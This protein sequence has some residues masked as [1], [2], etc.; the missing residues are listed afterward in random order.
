ME[1]FKGQIRSHGGTRDFTTHESA[2]R[3]ADERAFIERELA[4]ANEKAWRW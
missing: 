1:D 4:S 3:H 2:R